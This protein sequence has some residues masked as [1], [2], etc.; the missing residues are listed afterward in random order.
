VGHYWSTG[1]VLFKQ[2]R[3]SRAVQ[4]KGTQMSRRE[5]RLVT[6]TRATIVSCLPFIFAI[7]I[8]AAGYMVIAAPLLGFDAIVPFYFLKAARKEEV[9]A[10]HAVRRRQAHSLLLHYVRQH[11]MNSTETKVLHEAAS[12][13]LAGQ[14]PVSSESMLS[15]KNLNREVVNMTATSPRDYVVHASAIFLPHIS[16]VAA[17]LMPVE[18]LRTMMLKR[19]AALAAD[20][21][22]IRREGLDTLSE[23]EV[24]EAITERG[25]VSHYDSPEKLRE[26]LGAYLEVSTPLDYNEQ[27]PDLL[28]LL[29]TLSTPQYVVTWPIPESSGGLG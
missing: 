8:P 18:M 15:I 4:A 25:L 11:T 23:E 22:V 10:K 17:S 20:D 27:P 3:A 9:L 2:W 16:E 13:V 28:P 21:L 19:A 26:C 12:L 1:G 5:E 24:L 29:V 7:N 6:G 14:G